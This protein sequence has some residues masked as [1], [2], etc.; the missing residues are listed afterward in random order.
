[1]ASIINAS[2]SGAGGVATTADAS[3]VLDIQ[4]AGTT[5]IEINATQQVSMGSAAIGSDKFQIIGNTGP[6]SS[7]TLYRYAAST[8]PP[9]VRF[10]KSRG[11]SI[12]TQGALL[13]GDYI[14]NLEFDGSDGTQFITTANLSTF[15]DGTVS[16]NIIPSM[17]VVNVMNSS[18]SQYNQLLVRANG[19]T[20]FNSGYGSAATAY[21]C[22]AWVRFTGVGSVTISGNGNVTSVTRNATGD[23]TVNFTSAM[24]DANFAA[25]IS[26]SDDINNNWNASRC[27]V[28]N[29]YQTASS[30]RINGVSAG[31]A[32]VDLACCNVAI[33]R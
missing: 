20:Q 14:G 9:N 19:D 31:G 11:A 1:M 17:F 25:V 28:E 13:N 21:G 16:T 30:V 26:G 24:P 5:A 3:G 4:T 7:Q 10:F 27:W 12:G 23:Y 15:V 32:A 22:R 6:T 29:R 33:L 8:N 2:T 18:G